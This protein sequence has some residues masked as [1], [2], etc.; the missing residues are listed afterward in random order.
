MQ[1]QL[2]LALQAAELSTQIFMSV[3]GIDLQ[4]SRQMLS[5][6]YQVAIISNLLEFH[7]EYCAGI[8]EYKM[9]LF[10]PLETLTKPT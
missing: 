7:K 1:S 3:T 2:I 5:D 8:V 9:I 4:T 6:E 10:S